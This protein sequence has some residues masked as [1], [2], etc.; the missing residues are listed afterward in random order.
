LRTVAKL[1]LKAVSNLLQ[2]QKSERMKHLK[3]L[4]LMKPLIS[5][6]GII[7]EESLINKK[8]SKWKEKSLSL[9]MISWTRFRTI[10][11]TQL[12]VF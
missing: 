2:I 12:G 4:K 5:Q 9:T 7:L 11:P 1:Y 10:N 8:M 3:V 6:I